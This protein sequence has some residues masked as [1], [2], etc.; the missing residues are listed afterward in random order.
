MAWWSV[1]PVKRPQK[2]NTDRI[3][4]MGATL[5]HPRFQGN[6][7]T[8]KPGLGWVKHVKSK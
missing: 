3:C 2:Q 4:L 5:T 6:F 1:Q 7:V 8:N